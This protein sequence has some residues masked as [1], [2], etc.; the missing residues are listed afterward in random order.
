[1]PTLT[2]IPLNPREKQVIGWNFIMQQLSP[3]TPYGN[4]LKA[5]TGIYSS[6]DR[7]ELLEE[8]E[9]IAY[10]IKSLQ[11]SASIHEKLGYELIK[12]KDIR[13]ILRKLQSNQNLDEV[14][15]YELKYTLLV[16]QRIIG[17]YSQLD[18][19]I[20]NIQF[21]DLSE[22][23]SILDPQHT[24]LPTFQYYPEYSDRLQNIQKE[25]KSLENTMFQLQKKKT[26]EKKV[27]NAEFLDELEHLKQKR[28]LLVQQEQAEIGI[29]RRNLSHQ[30]LSYVHNFKSLITSLGNLDWLLE[31]AK[32][33]LQFSGCRPDI[34]KF[35]KKKEKIALK[36]EEMHNPYIA[37]LLAARNRSFTSLSVQFSRGVNLITGANMGGKTVLLYTTLLNILLA[38]S[39]FYVF[40]KSADI[41]LGAFFSSIFTDNQD[42][43]QGLSSFGAE[44]VMFNRVLL[45][46][47]NEPG[48]LFI[49]EFARG[50]NPSEGRMIFKAIVRYLQFLPWISVLTTHY[51]IKPEPNVSNFQVV[52]L[53]NTDL[54][55]LAQKLSN[56]QDDPSRS[57][58]LIQD[59]MDYHIIPVTSNTSIP[60][61]AINIAQILGLKPA[62]IQF[63][64][65]FIQNDLHQNVKE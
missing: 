52:G 12:L 44:I 7:Q 34:Q 37:S 19:S 11:N 29:I 53:R 56:I 39:G 15:F 20:K 65:E 47:E 30:L 32:L 43:S 31:K 26:V 28:T 55:A 18:L 49:D 21:S 17:L 23:L 64:K 51:D 10:M 41:P 62:I 63:A 16:S 61:D 33:A 4:T 24:Q 42:L 27:K 5:N 22:S 59:H 13:P 57:V 9:N 3:E 14:D 54:S 40:A 58:A 45:D 36:L 48:F 60:M 38:H 2:P 25:K 35:S 50:T 1:M 6:E 8:F 46:H